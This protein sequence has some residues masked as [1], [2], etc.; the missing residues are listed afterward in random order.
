M[1][2][3]THFIIRFKIVIIIALAIMCSVTT[4]AQSDPGHSFLNITSVADEPEESQDQ[5]QVVEQQKAEVVTEQPYTGKRFKKFVFIDIGTSDLEHIG[6]PNS[7]D[8]HGYTF[9]L[10]GQAGYRLRSAHSYKHSIISAGLELRNFNPAYTL[11]DPTI[12]LTKDKLYFWYA[13]VPV[14]YQYINT[15]HYAGNKN[16]ANLYFQA[17]VSLGYKMMM[18]FA[19]EDG[20]ETPEDNTK[21]YKTLMVQPFLSAGV[22][23][24]TSKNTYLFGPFVAATM[25]SI[26]TDERVTSTISSYGI[27]LSIIFPD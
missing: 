26:S 19:R 20:Y 24:T 2:Y 1:R 5:E 4:H 21:N 12:G 18:S 3:L 6:R 11:A 16:D 13:G 10:G 14:M 9:A 15:K 25:N 22:S 7:N 8:A 23:Y 27:R 17:G